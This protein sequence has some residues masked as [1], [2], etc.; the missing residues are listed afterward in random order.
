[1]RRVVL[2]VLLLGLIAGQSEAASL[3]ISGDAYSGPIDTL[4]G[5]LP[6]PDVLYINQTGTTGTLS[7]SVTVPFL[8]CCGNTSA[9]ARAEAGYGVLRSVSE[10]LVSGLNGPPYVGALTAASSATAKFADTLTFLGGAGN[11][12]ATVQVTLSGG[13]TA[14]GDTGS[15]FAPASGGAGYDLRITSNCYPAAECLHKQGSANGQ[16]D[17]S[18]T[19]Y[20]TLS[21]LFGQPIDIAA[22]LYTRAQADGGLGPP[23]LSASGAADYGGTFTWDGIV[24]VRDYQGIV[25]NFSVTSDSGTNYAVSAVPLPPT[26]ALVLPGVLAALSFTRRRGASA[27]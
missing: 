27:R 5:Q 12:T 17:P 2:S 20:F 9:M 18:G 24:E 6:A 19:Y 22:E 13:L 11:G 21:F 3:L 25:N 7:D 15:E 4:G 23:G 10:A 8:G 14:S 16:I 26:L 1:M